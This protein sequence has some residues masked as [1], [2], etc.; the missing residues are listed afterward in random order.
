MVEA[1]K[2]KKSLIQGIRL[3]DCLET[4]SL[5]N[6]RFILTRE[7]FLLEVTFLP[8]CASIGIIIK[9]ALL[10]VFNF[11]AKNHYL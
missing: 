6:L 3:L 11:T 5:S 2:G 10:Y 8:S 9:L 1:W 4:K 7:F